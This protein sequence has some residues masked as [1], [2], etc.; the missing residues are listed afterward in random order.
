MRRLVRIAGA[1]LALR[2]TLVLFAPSS[3]A[4]SH[5]VE[6][7]NNSFLP[8]EMTV[9]VGDTITWH[10]FDTAQDQVHSVVGGPI[11]SPD[12]APNGGEFKWTFNAPGLINYTCR[13]H[14]YMMGT[15]N[16]T[17]VP[18]PAPAPTPA[19][20]PAAPAATPTTS[21]AKTTA[22]TSSASASPP[23]ALMAKASP[24]PLEEDLVTETTSSLPT[25]APLTDVST[26]TT[27]TTEQS[28]GA[29]KLASKSSNTTGYV[30]LTLSVVIV[31]GAWLAKRTL[32]IKEAKGNQ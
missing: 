24:T 22:T 20:T 23:A 13:F 7:R 17:S 14:T 18:A 15:I 26:T 2:S 3:I 11:T 9:G 29:L 6:I 30:F 10:N 31:V 1:A 28:E 27:P 5:T 16:V 21:A 8:A 4:A 32:S 25:L 19:P 12:I